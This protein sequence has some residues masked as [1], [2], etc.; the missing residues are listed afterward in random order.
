MTEIAFDGLADSLS[1][2]IVGAGDEGY[3]E[4]RTVWNGRF[5]RRPEVV[6]RCRSTDDVKAAGIH[7]AA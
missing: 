4:A 5:D 2:E 6:V 3:R 1:G 7:A